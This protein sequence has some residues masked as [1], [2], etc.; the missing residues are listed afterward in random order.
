MQRGKKCCVH[1]RKRLGRK[2]EKRKERRNIF[3]YE[4]CSI[5]VTSSMNLAFLPSFFTSHEQSEKE[6]EGKSKKSCLA[7]LARSAT[8]KNVQHEL[9]AR[10]HTRTH[11]VGQKPRSTNSGRHVPYHLSAQTDDSSLLFTGYYCK[12]ENNPFT[13]CMRF[14]G[15]KRKN[16]GNV[17]KTWITESFV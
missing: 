17:K 13:D 16:V 9:R 1:K 8:G 11:A 3:L 10:T 12:R 7:M 14:L 5:D 4:V 6:R 2:R 15:R